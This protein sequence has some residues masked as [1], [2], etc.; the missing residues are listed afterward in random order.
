MIWWFSTS[1]KKP[2]KTFLF[3]SYLQEKGFFSQKNSNC[4]LFKTLG[5]GR[6][7]QYKPAIIKRMDKKGVWFTESFHESGFWTEQNKQSVW[8][9]I[10]FEQ[11]EGTNKIFI[12]S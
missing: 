9:K 6:V 4:L 1:V 12:K 8:C 7:K 3:Y 2:T 10:S 5:T 11:V